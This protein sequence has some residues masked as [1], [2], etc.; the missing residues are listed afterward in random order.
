MTDLTSERP[1]RGYANYVL[2]VLVLVYVFN[3]IDRQILSILAEDVK[4]DLGITDAY[5]G[6]LYGTAFGVFYALFG[7]PLGRLADNWHRIRLLTLGLG[8]W[9]AMTALSGFA[10]TPL[11]LT[12]A[13]VGVGIGEATASPS[14]YSLISDYFP[15]AQRATALAIYSSGLYI[16][17]GLSL[18]IG[19]LV[20]GQWNAAYPGGGPLGLVGW[21]A[22]FLAVGI[23]GI[24]LALWVSTLREPIRGISDGIVTP[25]APRPFAD[26]FAELLTII[27]PLT[28]IGAAKRGPKALAINLGFAV[29]CGAIAWG[30]II[31]TKNP[32]QWIAMG[33]GIYAVFSW[34]SALRMRDPVTFRLIWGTPA[35]LQVALGYGLIAFTAYAGSFWGAPYAIR[36]WA[37]P[38]IDAGQT[39]PWYGTKTAIGFFMGGSGAL[40]GFIGVVAGGRLSDWLLKSRPNGRILVIL[41]GLLA[42]VPFYIITYTTDNLPLYYVLNFVTG[43]LASAALGPAA[44]TTQDLVLP[45]M[46]GTATATFFLGNAMIGLGL[47]PSLAGIV[48]TMSGS[49]SIG[50]LSL[51]VS[52]PV[53]AALLFFAYRGI[54][55]AETTLVARAGAAGEPV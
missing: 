43:V 5:L 8:L 49:L 10:K 2:F 28:L 3:F 1:S 18:G 44:A 16:G 35:F 15:K 11:Q 48:S 30:L 46:R 36:T 19:A 41:V 50:M 34:V 17:G 4:R 9:S 14:A 33:I 37:Q 26:F 55:T 52:V 53:S 40:S 27:P 20:V 51:L 25:T 7:I 21:Q 47:G 29:I 31:V 45:R 22:A 12:L 39:L 6:F 13:R 54:A 23:P 24:L 38:M 42:P 32:P